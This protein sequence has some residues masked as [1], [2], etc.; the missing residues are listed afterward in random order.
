MSGSG[1]A[2]ENWYVLEELG[3][4][5]R[6]STQEVDPAEISYGKVAADTQYLELLEVVAVNL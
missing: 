1:D 6:R 4:M 3:C 2:V 5:E